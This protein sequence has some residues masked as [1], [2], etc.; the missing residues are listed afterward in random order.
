MIGWEATSRGYTKPTC[1]TAAFSDERL[2]AQESTPGGACRAFRSETSEY[3]TV[4]SRPLRRKARL[5]LV[6]RLEQP[7]HA[8]PLDRRMLAP[9]S[10]SVSSG[11]RAIPD[12]V[13]SKLHS[14][15]GEAHAAE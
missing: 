7:R 15:R 10:D 13:S 1:R 11:G 6:N 3:R 5:D 14:H 2:N 8:L 12:A 4:R 9:N